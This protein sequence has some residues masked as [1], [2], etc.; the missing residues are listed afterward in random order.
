MGFGLHLPRNMVL[1][2]KAPAKPEFQE[3]QAGDSG[4]LNWHKPVA[5]TTCL[6][7]FKDWIKSLSS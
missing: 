7:F 4:I 3:G 2:A 1:S 5:Y 6:G